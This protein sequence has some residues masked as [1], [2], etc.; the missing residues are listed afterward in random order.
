MKELNASYGV[1]TPQELRRNRVN[2]GMSQHP[3]YGVNASPCLRCN[4][5]VKEGWL[6]IFIG[7][8]KDL[9][10]SRTSWKSV[11]PVRNKILVYPDSDEEDEEYCSLPLLLPC[12]QTPQPYATFNFV[13]HN[14]HSEVDI[15]NMSLEEYARYELA[16]S[17]MKSEIQE[18]SSLDKILDDLFRI[19]AKNIRKMEHEVPNRCDNITDYEDSDQED[20]ELPDLPNFFVTNEFASVCEQVKEN[21]D[22]NTAQELKEV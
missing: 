18:D 10:R 13:H 7:R 12:F 16:V 15:K 14:S 8:H 4:Q 5:T 20:G 6:I 1:T 2:E 19:G 3:S 22:V 17:T 11:A 9:E 21:I